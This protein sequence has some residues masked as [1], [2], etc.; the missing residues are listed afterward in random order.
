MSEQTLVAL[1][2]AIF[3]GGGLKLIEHILSRSKTRIDLAGELRNELR[4]EVNN[5]KDEVREVDHSLDEWKGRYY[6]LLRHYH[7]IRATCIAQG[8]DVPEFI[9]ENKI[10]E[11]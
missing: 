2:A 9:E 7:D 8:I 11:N 3:G 4:T 1:A 5:L 10:K 6:R